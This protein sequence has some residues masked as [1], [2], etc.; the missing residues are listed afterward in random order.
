MQKR[1]TCK[2]IYLFI[3]LSYLL[4]SCKYD[5]EETID[6]TNSTLPNGTHI[7]VEKVNKKTTSRG[8]ITNHKYG[9][10]Y[11]FTYKFLVHQGNISWDG[12]SAEPKNILFCKDTT[13]IRYLKKKRIKTEYFDTTDSTTQYNYHTEIHEYFEKH[14]DKRYFFQLLG[15]AY[16]IEITPT[17]YSSIKDIC[18]EY[19]IPNDNELSIEFYL[20][21]NEYEK[22]KNNLK[23]IRTK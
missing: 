2:S 6:K 14:I 16:W 8:L 4:S 9:V 22:L 23:N 11:S 7:I 13:Y 5:S 12:G 17:H 1:I 15:D 3:L 19:D 18:D 20:K 21:S 10:S